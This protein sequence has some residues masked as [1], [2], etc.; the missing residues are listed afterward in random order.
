MV[1]LLTLLKAT[2]QDDQ[3]IAHGVEQSITAADL[4]ERC[5]KLAS[6][7]IQEK[8]NVVALHGD[9]SIN[10]LIIDLA[11][12]EANICIIP[13]P[14]FFSTQ[15]LQHVFDVAPIDAILST[16]KELFFSLLPEQIIDSKNIALDDYSLCS[17]KHASVNNSLPRNTEKITFTSGSTG[18]P[19]GVC[20]S[21]DQLCKQ[22]I[23]LS[24]VTN[25]KKQRHLCLLPLST[26]LENVAG[27]YMPLLSGGEVIIPSLL[28]IG[29]CGSSAL[30]SDKFC[31]S[32]SRYQP[33]SI[34][35][36]PQLL[37]TLISAIEKGWSLPSSLEFIAV[38]GSKL[39]RHQLDRARSLDLPVYEGYGISECAS[40]VSLNTARD[41]KLGTC[42]KVLP[43]LTVAIDHDEIIVSGNTML[44]YLGEPDSWNKKRFITGDLGALDEEG[45][46]IINGRKKNVLISSY[47]RNISPEWVE[48]E[49][50][51][52]APIAE[53]VVLGDA[54]PYCVALL[55]SQ[56]S[57]SSNEAIQQLID[58]S[59]ARLPDY[60]RVKRWH[61]LS[62]PLSAHQSLV[63]ENGRPRRQAIEAYYQ[64]AIES[65]YISANG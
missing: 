16:Q 21:N 6:L 41:N 35:I 19:K 63:T 31:Q 37:A 12:Q 3:L 50:L 39:S 34:V 14:T 53:C 15:Q 38:G 59:N 58:I 7:L 43:H 62:R 47:G 20:L 65:L 29:F 48:S 36:T 55:S 33:S 56:S 4:V 24:E 64:D 25:L 27:L 42:G 5:K 18:E 2:H 44:G 13:L 9:N 26:L 46:L 30:G 45:Y 61:R 17:L 32:I 60:A 22:A 54:K 40:V 49:L 10:W 57:D 11:C 52:H 28:E 23:A 8:I 51:S 1:N